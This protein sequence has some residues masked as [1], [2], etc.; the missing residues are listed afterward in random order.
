MGQIAEDL[1]I[2]LRTQFPD[3]R[4][5][6]LVANRRRNQLYISLSHDMGMVGVDVG[7]DDLSDLQTMFAG[8]C[9]ITH[10][11]LEPPASY[12]RAVGQLRMMTVMLLDSDRAGKIAWT[13]H[14]GLT[15]LYLI[16]SRDQHVSDLTLQLDNTAP[17]LHMLMGLIYQQLHREPKPPVEEELYE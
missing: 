5:V 12:T 9:K 7:L 8:L 3:G 10:M 1:D 11:R 16:S 4:G 6:F 13:H 2:E 14:D 17:L 15:N